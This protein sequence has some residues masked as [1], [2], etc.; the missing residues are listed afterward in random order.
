[1]YR[2]CDEICIMQDGTSQEK[3][4]TSDLFRHPKTY[5][6]AL[7]S[8][9]KNYSAAEGTGE[10]EARAVDWGLTLSL[11]ENPD[12]NTVLGI[13]SRNIELETEPKENSFLLEDYVKQEELFSTVIM[14]KTPKE[15]GFLRIEVEKDEWEEKKLLKP[16]YVCLNKERIIVM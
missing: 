14:V 13:R 11:C 16:L 3:R 10:K 6:A 7:L 15:G 8:G 2:L 4:E 9:C 1:M 5:A 12:E